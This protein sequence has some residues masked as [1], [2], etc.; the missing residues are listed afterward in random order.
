[1][2]SVKNFSLK[3]NESGNENDD[4][5]KEEL[6]LDPR[7][8][9]WLR[10]VA[11][12]GTYRGVSYMFCEEQRL[13]YITHRAGVVGRGP[14]PFLGAGIDQLREGASSTRK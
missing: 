4:T 7:E 8:E 12:P 9:Y 13:R 6:E 14:A 5:A 11:E 2:D 1:M 3:K 10:G